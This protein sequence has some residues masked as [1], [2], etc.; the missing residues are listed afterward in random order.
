MYSTLLVLFTL[1]LP[2]AYSYFLP[3]VEADQA[4]SLIKKINNLFFMTGA[5]F[6]FALYMGSS[7][8]AF[9]LRNPELD[10]ALKIFSPVPF[11]MLPTMG[12]EGILASFRMTKLMALYTIVT[13]LLMLICVAVPVVFFNGG[14]I[15]AIIGFVFASG[16]SLT[17]ALF[18]KSYPVRDKEKNET[19]IEYRGILEFSLP[20]LYASLW[21][22]LINAADQFYISRYFGSEVFAEFAN[23]SLE[24]P[25]I[26]M[27]VGATT[28]VLSP[29][30]SR[31]SHEKANPLKDIFPI[32]KSVFEKSALLIYPLL[33]YVWIFSDQ[34]MIVLYGEQYA[35]SAVFFKIKAIVNFF[36]VIAYGPLLINTGKVKFYAKVHM[37]T[38]FSVLALE[39]AAVM[40]FS[41]PY[42][43]SIVSMLCQL[44]KTLCLLYA[45]AKVFQLKL[46]ELFPMKII[47]KIFFISLP[48]LAIDYYLLVFFLELSEL[49]ILILGF[50]V[51]IFIYMC[52]AVLLG[53][54]YFSIIRSLVKK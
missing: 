27:I 43:V 17:L 6:S 15:E 50:L 51:Y 4:R 33:I 54:D 37:Y 31:M 19:E 42:A 38:A 41:S 18:F 32:W 12:L 48:V 44:F 24:L 2:R 26:G 52:G 7:Y 25:F 40:L 1:G 8:I 22:I 49:L 28:A 21:G 45:V 39:Y 34:I 14:Y 47:G 46:L 30:F 16:F 13:R 35:S 29:V 3:R 11:L 5:I 53:L 23:G 10:L 36:T 9:F 20:L